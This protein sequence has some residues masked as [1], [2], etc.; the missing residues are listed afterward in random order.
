[1]FLQPN[2]SSPPAFSQLH[3]VSVLPTTCQTHNP[4]I[5]T[6]THT[7]YQIPALSTCFWTSLEKTQ[8]QKKEMLWNLFYQQLHKLKISLSLSHTR[9]H[10]WSS[11][12]APGMTWES[13]AQVSDQT[14]RDIASGFQICVGFVCVCVFVYL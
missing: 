2:Q 1:L 12:V 4:N 10:T 14:S 13:W 5:P 7:H 11:S 6:H 9:A 3:P 8:K